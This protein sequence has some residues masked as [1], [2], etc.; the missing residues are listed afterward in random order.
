MAKKMSVDSTEVLPPSDQRVAEVGH[1][2]DEADQEGVGQPRLHQRQVTVR[3]VCQRAGAQRLRGL[4][5]R[6]ADALHDAAHDHEGDRREGE[7]LRQPARRTSRRT[8]AWAGCRRPSSRNWLTRPARPNSRISPRPTTKGGVMIGSS[9]RTLSGLG[10]PRA[11]AFG[12][13]RD[14]R[15]QHRGAGRREQRQEQ[16]VPGHAAA[17]A[18]DQAGQAPDPVLAQPLGQRGQ[19]GAGRPR[20]G[21]P[22]SGSCPPAARRTAAAAPSRTPPRRRRTGR[23]ESSPAA[24]CP[25]PAASAGQQHQRAAEADAGLP[26]R[27]LAEPGVQ[28]LERPAAWRRWQSRWPAGRPGPAA[29]PSHQLQPCAATGGPPARPAAQR[30]P[31]QRRATARAGHAQRL[32]QR[33]WPSRAAAEAPG[34]EAPQRQVLRE[35]PGQQHE[36]RQPQQRQPATARV[37][38]PCARSSRIRVPRG[39]EPPHRPH[40]R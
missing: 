17:H 3:K 22:R 8:S 18:A 35:V 30:Q 28:R 25:R 20:R 5:Q 15:A 26:R 40:L 1:A 13:Q 24:P 37:I 9:A 10:Q 7:Q 27:Q 32:H 16:R 6:G 11:G 23:R 19:R 21:R 2:L 33:R 14:Q 12:Q 34:S 36:G 38:W 31:E 39:H 29:A 4:F